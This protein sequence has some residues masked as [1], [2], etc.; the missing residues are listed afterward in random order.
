MNQV[1]IQIG[2]QTWIVPAPNV[3]SLIS[4]LNMNAVSADRQVTEVAMSGST[5]PRQLLMESN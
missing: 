2:H 5:D 1:T 3:A 4:W